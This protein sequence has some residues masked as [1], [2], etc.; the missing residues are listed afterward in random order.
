MSHDGLADDI[1]VSSRYRDLLALGDDKEFLYYKA[2]W[3]TLGQIRQTVAAMNMLLDGAG[4]GDGA[5]I[6]LV[7][8]T[9]PAH[10][11]AL[12]ALLS[13][14][15]CV[16]PITSIQSDAGV[17]ADVEHLGLAALIADED[18][19]GRSELREV[20]SR[21]GVLGIMVTLAGPA[22]IEGL[23]SCRSNPEAI[24]GA[25]VLMPTSGTTGPPKRIVYS[26]GHLNGA[27]GR[28]AKYARSVGRTLT[29]P[30]SIQRSVT[31]ATLALAH[32]GGF[33]AV[34]QAAAEGR[35]IA[36]LD[37]FE[38]REWADLVVYHQAR[39]SALPPTA[40][41]MVL[42]ADIPKEKLASLLAVNC[43]TAP[44][45][46]ALGD[47]FTHKYGPPVLTA[48][49]AT[50]FPGGLVGWT[51][52]DY[53]RFHGTKR[54][55]VGRP[56]PGIK[57][58]IVDPGTGADKGPEEVGQVR[59]LSP[60]AT[61]STPDGWVTTNDIGRMDTENFL[62]L[63]GRADDAINRGGFKI[64]PQSV[65]SVLRQHPAIVEAAVTGIPDRRLG[66]VPV[67]AVTIRD[68][69]EMADLVEWAREH[70]PKYQVPVQFKIVEEL[71][72]T[73]S[74]KVTK[75]GVRALFAAPL[76]RSS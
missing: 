71:P 67:A 33:W 7:T 48:Y 29:G 52:E 41:R 40:I 46:P 58:K 34:F 73:T 39:L 66:Q 62:W 61:A 70:L 68:A 37:R 4:V 1:D 6:G 31:I 10:V 19:W 27:L 45:D 5:K 74:L 11:A 17:A 24:P 9:R 16:V 43:G 3:I 75:E 15:R 30:V 32:V 18:D 36:L 64:V 60:Q 20:S 44:L 65:E 14:R 57:V 26:Y 38:P 47:E 23:G 35:P 12:L 28:V 2:A 55:S 21:L 54:G 42:D 25:A 69:I 13:T 72:R 8:R 53:R 59:V 56:R 51:L 49:G 22:T 50:E 76:W 63:L